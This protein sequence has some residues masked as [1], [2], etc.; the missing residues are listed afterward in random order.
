[1]SWTFWILNVVSH[2]HLQFWE[3]FNFTYAC[4]LLGH[5]KFEDVS[6]WKKNSSVYQVEDGRAEENVRNGPAL[7]SSVSGAILASC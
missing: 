2:K 1:M 7:S 5:H 3:R 6:L 4:D